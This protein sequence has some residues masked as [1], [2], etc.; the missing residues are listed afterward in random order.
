MKRYLIFI[1]WLLCLSSQAQVNQAQIDAIIPKEK[2]KTGIL[3][4]RVMPFAGLQTFGQNGRK[5]TSHYEHF[6]QAYYELYQASYNNKEMLR[7]EQ[8]RNWIRYKSE[9]NML[10]LGLIHYNFNYSEDLS[11]DK[12]SQEGFTPPP[13]LII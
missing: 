10:L 6:I 7:L 1:F 13:I 5:D 4:N 2:V 8:I 3:Y 12:I 11:L 9:R